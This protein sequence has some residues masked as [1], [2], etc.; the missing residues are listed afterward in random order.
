MYLVKAKKDRFFYVY[1]AK[2]TRLGL[3][4][5]RQQLI[6]YSCGVELTS[7]DVHVPWGHRKSVISLLFLL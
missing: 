6:T 4:L 1:T 5:E 2:V 3:V 7:E